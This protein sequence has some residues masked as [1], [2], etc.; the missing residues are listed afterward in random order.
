MSG[1][2][3]Q[4]VGVVLMVSLLVTP[5]SAARQWTQ[6][7]PIM[8]AL[9][10]AFGAVSG[11]A[12]A[13]ISATELRVPTGPVVVLIATLIFV[14]SILFAPSRGIVARARARREGMEGV[15]T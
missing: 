2:R 4:A 5:A 15:A 9:A 14:V 3:L 6:R 7:L 8:V 10:A 13:L 11:L 12:G 1:Y